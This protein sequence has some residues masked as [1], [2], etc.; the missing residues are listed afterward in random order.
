[1]R[2][3]RAKAEENRRAVI[4]AAGRLF[5]ERGFDGIGLNDLMGAAGLTQGGFYK[6]FESKADLIAQACQRALAEGADK[7]ARTV[8]GPG[9][10]PFA[11]LVGRYLT[12]NHRDHVGE[13]CAFAALAPDAARQ[14]GP[15]AR[16]FEAGLRAQLEQL[17]RA[18]KASPSHGTHD[19]PVVVFSTMVGALLLSRVVEDEEF[20]RHILRA[21]ARSL[22]NPEDAPDQEDGGS[23]E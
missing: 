15:V 6:Q 10:D 20:A 7:W 19:D 17:D 22:L 14:G 21:A 9:E 12:Y 5:R 11:E 23:K 8:D 4:D 3:S 18:M 1:M 2:V 13:G 16:S